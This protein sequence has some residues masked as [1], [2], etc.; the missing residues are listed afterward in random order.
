M[1]KRISDLKDFMEYMAQQTRDAGYDVE[2]Y[3]G[4][5][6]LV[7]IRGRPQTLQLG[8]LYQG[9]LEDSRRLDVILDSHFQLLRLFPPCQLLPTDRKLQD[10]LLPMIQSQSWLQ[11]QTPPALKPF[12]VSEPI[13]YSL[14]DDLVVV[15][16]IDTP[17][18]RMYLNDHVFEDMQKLFDMTRES[19]HEISLKNLRRRTSRH[20]TQRSGK[21]MMT[22]LGCNTGDGHSAARVLLPKFMNRWERLVPGRL[23]IG[24]PSRDVM[25]G[26]TE[27]TLNVEALGNKIYM[28][29]QNYKNKVSPKLFLWE[30]GQLHL[31]DKQVI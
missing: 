18:V 26:F 12:G 13:H 8:S 9:Y 4:S 27:H 3:I 23:L 6:L 2:T 19:L 5:A 10:S 20:S 11:K 24:L 14:V 22:I 30:N 29:Y 15:Y 31:Y 25:I 28:D 21:G 1:A 7:T 16:V 17:Y